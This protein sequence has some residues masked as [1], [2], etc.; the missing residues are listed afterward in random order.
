MWNLYLQWNSKSFFFFLSFQCGNFSTPSL[1]RVGTFP[2][3]HFWV[4][5]FLGGNFSGWEL[6]RTPFWIRALLVFLTKLSPVFRSR[7][8]NRSSVNNNNSLSHSGFLQD[9]LVIRGKGSP[10]FILTLLGDY[11]LSFN[12]RIW[13][14]KH[15]LEQGPF[16]IPWILW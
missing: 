11:T 9:R 15:P 5:T 6:F 12:S 16:E 7:P 13:L 2:G 3:G 4:G 14:S 10:E 8:N 1:L